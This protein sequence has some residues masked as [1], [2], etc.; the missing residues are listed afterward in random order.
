[1][2]RI[3]SRYVVGGSTAIPCVRKSP[4]TVS[5]I[6][7]TMARTGGCSVSGGVP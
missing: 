4:F 1:M 3:G 7:V 5:A 6:S 2:K